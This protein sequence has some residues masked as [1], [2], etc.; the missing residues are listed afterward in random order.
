MKKMAKSSPLQTFVHDL[1]RDTAL[2]AVLVVVVVM[3]VVVVTGD[4][5]GGEEDLSECR[6]FLMGFSFYWR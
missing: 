3:V 5:N 2:A 6:L 4:E 1:H